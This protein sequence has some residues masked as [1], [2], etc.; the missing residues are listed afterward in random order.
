MKTQYFRD[1]FGH[2]AS[3]LVQVEVNRALLITTS[4]WPDGNLTTTASVRTLR[5]GKFTLAVSSDGLGDFYKKLEVTRPGRSTAALVKAQ[6]DACL[7]QLA[8]LQ[9][10]IDNHYKAQLSEEAHCVARD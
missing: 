8:D 5:Q 9:Q 7:V 10:E 1:E 4:K 3:T 6:H 2:Q